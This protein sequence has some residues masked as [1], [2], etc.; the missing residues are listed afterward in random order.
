MLLSPTPN[1]NLAPTN[2]YSTPRVSSSPVPATV[3]ANR[4]SFCSR[5]LHADGIVVLQVASLP[6]NCHGS[7]SLQM[8]S[9]TICLNIFSSILQYVGR[10]PIVGNRVPIHRFSLNG[11][12]S[13]L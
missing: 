5:R 7:E 13:L 2:C 11:L 12:I 10:L 8:F 4:H 1:P 6:P 3:P 9:K